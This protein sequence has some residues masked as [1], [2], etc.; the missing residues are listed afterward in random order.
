MK[1]YH[2][3]NH[4]LHYLLAVFVSTSL[5][6]FS[7][8][9]SIFNDDSISIADMQMVEFGE[10]VARDGEQF[11][12]SINVYGQ[13]FT[14]LLT[15]NTSLNQQAKYRK[16]ATEVVPYSGSIEGVNGS[17][18]R[19]TKVAGNY[20]GAFYDGNELFLIDDAVKASE[21][22]N[23]TA[24]A[25]HGSVAFTASSVSNIGHCDMDLRKNSSAFDYSEIM[26]A[27]DEAELASATLASRE[28]AITI[29]ADTEY[30]ASSGSDVEGN[31]IAQM[32][33][34]D[35]IFSDQLGLSMAVADI[36]MLSAN[37]TLTSNNASTLIGAFRSYVASDIGNQGLTHLFTGKDLEGSTVGIAYVG[38]VCGSYGVGVT[39]AGSMSSIASLVAAHEFG[40][41]FSA[42]HDNESGSACAAAAGTYLMNPTINGND[43][44]SDCSLSIIQPIVDGASCIVD[45]TPVADT[46]PTIISTANPHA[47]T[48]IA[49]KYD[50]D[51]QIE[52]DGTESITY[53]LDFGPVGMTVDP[54]GLVSWTP[55]SNQEGMHSVQITA[56]N[57]YGTDSQSFDIEVV[58][59][60]DTSVINFN[61]F[62]LA[63][64]GGNQDITGTVSV[65]DG[66]ATLTMQG[67]K[68]QKI[69]MPYIVTQ[70][71]ILELDFKS[72][73]EGE[74][75]GIGFDNNISLNENKIFRVYGSQA[76]GNGAYQY[77]GS[78]DFEHFVIPVGD[79]YTGSM[80]NL[81]FAMDHDVGSPTGNSYFSNI[82][83]YEAGEIPVIVAPSITSS[84]N[85]SA[86]VNTAYAYDEDN[87][88][89]AD[90][91]A[92]ISYELLNGPT[93]MTISQ[94]GLIAWTPD[95]TQEGQ[96][97]I[98]VGASN[99]AGMDTQSF[100]VTVIAATDESVLNFNDYEVLSYGGSQDVEGIVSIEDGGATLKLE[101]NTWK[102]IDLDILLTS[103][104]VLVFDFKST[105]QGEL[106]GFGFDNNLKLTENRVFTLFGTQDYGYT[107]Y[108][109]TGDGEYQHFEIPVGAFYRGNFSNLFFM[110]DHD[111]NNPDGNSYFKN[112]QLID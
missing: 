40:H 94:E 29:V 27:V 63:A 92:I 82:Q 6:S 96:Q 58:A 7:V 1:F 61:D 69:D 30:V 84:P 11:A 93:G 34:V 83:V 24:L 49:Y 106:H 45:I 2:S 100:V 74:V 22:T 17:W 10:S 54:T 44:F 23:S 107:N 19:L 8:D 97:V 81:F 55:Q 65:T 5:L 87:S 99:S 20:I 26:S 102:R 41:N 89:S 9:A 59:P 88:L 73:Q 105:S 46:P 75:H 12:L 101:G 108:T 4:R 48:N 64:Y 32:N 111:V 98:E 77:S 109:Y 38:G 43:Q 103:D 18:V 21:I 71:T 112:V 35:G 47:T 16:H 72:T 3:I 37:G 67:N 42:P 95:E 52:S 66:G 36:I 78:G 57:S 85:L 86:T 70:D 79:Y 14:F 13:S 91:T 68:W 90:G 56:V 15:E 25:S 51:S 28:I 80:T 76:Y 50:N 60:A 62:S 31:I 39:Q 104:S 53:L 33:V 110:M